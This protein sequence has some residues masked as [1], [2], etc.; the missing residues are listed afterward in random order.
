MSFIKSVFCF[1]LSFLFWMPAHAEDTAI[2]PTASIT[3]ISPDLFRIIEKSNK[4][5]VNMDRQMIHLCLSAATALSTGSYNSQSNIRFQ[6]QKY[7]VM[8]YIKP[9][10]LHVLGHFDVTIDLYDD[11]DQAYLHFYLPN[12]LTSA[13][14]LLSSTISTP[15]NASETLSYLT[16]LLK[17]ITESL[18]SDTDSDSLSKFLV[19]GKRNNETSDNRIQLTRQEDRDALLQAM[20]RLEWELHDNVTKLIDITKLATRPGLSNEEIR[21]LEQAFSDNADIFWQMGSLGFKLRTEIPIFH[22]IQLTIKD[23]AYFFPQIDLSTL[24]LESDN[25]LSIESAIEALQHAGKAY[26]WALSW[27]I[28]NQ[29]RLSEIEISRKDLLAVLSSFKGTTKQKQHLL[30]KINMI[31]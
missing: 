29:T 22:D 10:T 25:I 16:E 6:A 4:A 15:E 17:Q 14:K 1:S 26:Y 18:P 8:D 31:N 11:N 28:T 5:V 30:Q 19:Q 23:K 7:K 12:L 13:D 27:M 20:V 9:L 24:N 2:K 3:L 21:Q